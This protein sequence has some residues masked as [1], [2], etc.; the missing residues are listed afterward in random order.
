[1]AAIPNE[2][3]VITPSVAFAIDRARSPANP[4][5]S[6]GTT[7]CAAGGLRR[8]LSILPLHRVF[9]AVELSLLILFV[10]LIDSAA[11]PDLP[12]QGILLLVL[13]GAAAVSIPGRLW[14]ILNSDRL[15]P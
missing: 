15:D 11:T 4:P 3:L 2:A 13:A 8:A 10:A 14:V 6:G 7:N 1:M 5:A 12:A 9:G